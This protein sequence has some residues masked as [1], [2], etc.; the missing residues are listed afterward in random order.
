MSQLPR[1]ERETG[2]NV[3]ETLSI[4]V[5]GILLLTRLLNTWRKYLRIINDEREDIMEIKSFFTS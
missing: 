4:F 1:A 3:K 2:R 5:D